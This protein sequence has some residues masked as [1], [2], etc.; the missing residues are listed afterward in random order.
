MEDVEVSIFDP[1]SIEVWGGEGSGMKRG[2]V[3]VVA[4]ASHSYK[5][6]IF[7]NA[8]ITNILSCFCLSL[9][10]EEDNGVEMGLSSIIPYPPIARMIQILEITSEGGSDANGLG[11]RC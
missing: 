11:G 5:M 7:S 9:L 6:S 2:G 10:V 3:L 1:R 8:P 4:L